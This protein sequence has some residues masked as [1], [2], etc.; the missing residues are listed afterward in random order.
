MINQLKELQ[1]QLKEE[2]KDSKQPLELNKIVEENAIEPDYGKSEKPFNVFSPSQVGYCKRQM[3]NRKMNLTDMD[4]YIKGILHAGTVNH[5]WLEHKLPAMVEDRGLETERKFRNKIDI[6]DNDF[7][8]F[9]SG[10]ADAV[11][12][13]GYVYDHKFTSAPYYK[14]KGPSTKDKRQVMM[15]LYSLDDVHTGRLEYVKRDGKF[16][17]GEDNLIFHPVKF[18]PEEFKEVLD[19]MTEVAAAVK[20]RENT[21]LEKVNP[22]PYCDRDGGDACFYCEEDFKE[23]KKSVRVRLKNLDQWQ[24]W[25]EGEQIQIGLEE[26]KQKL[27]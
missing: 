10:Y 8:L 26:A 15:Y 18:D 2:K 11:D 7:D 16:E 5:F 19:N 21:E 24:K 6:P 25:K 13:E 27:V 17:K 14:K 20:E 9:V 1:D 12:T 23:T 3:Y 22:F 4:R